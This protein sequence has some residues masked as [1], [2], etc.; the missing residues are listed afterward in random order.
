MLWPQGCI[1]LSRD[2]YHTSQKSNKRENT[3]LPDG[4]TTVSI[5]GVFHNERH[6]GL[7]YIRHVAR[8]DIRETCAE[9]REDGETGPRAGAL[10][11]RGMNGRVA[12]AR[13][14]NRVGCVIGRHPWQE[15]RAS[16]AVRTTED[17][18]LSSFRL[19]VEAGVQP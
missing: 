1:A 14:D 13:K 8:A 5:H 10:D 12:G 15:T 17:P 18:S 11:V 16:S 19:L 9:V 6:C 2:R 3:I 4:G 7:F